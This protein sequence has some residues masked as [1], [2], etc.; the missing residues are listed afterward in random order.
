MLIALAITSVLAFIIG[1]VL[2]MI[3]CA[4]GVILFGAVTVYDTKK[5]RQF[6]SHAMSASD[7]SKY[8]IYSAMQLYLDYINI[9]LY[10]IRI[11][12]FFNRRR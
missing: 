6:A 9:L 7:E 12:G 10:L 1:G 2:E 5:V 11:L 4:V 3:V 8:A